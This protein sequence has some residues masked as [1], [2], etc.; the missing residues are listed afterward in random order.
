MQRSEA[1][2]GPDAQEWKPERWLDPKEAAKH[3]ASFE[4]V[5]F[6]AGPRI[7]R[8]V[9]LQIMFHS[10]LITSLFL[11]QP[12]GSAPRPEWKKD[13]DTQMGR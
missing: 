3:N 5:P 2:W 6:N 9:S 11:Y 4:F 12:E 1:L 13:D 10:F 8:L 7:V